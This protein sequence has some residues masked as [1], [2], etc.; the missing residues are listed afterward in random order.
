MKKK[1]F[2]AVCV[3]ALC[4]SLSPAYAEN[5]ETGGNSAPVAENF[6][7]CTYRNVSIGGQLAAVDPDGEPVTF[8]LTTEPVKGTVEI[9]ENGQFVYTPNEGKRGRDYFGYKAVDSSGNESQEATVIISI[10]KQKTDV[11]YSD[12]TG[13]AEE[14]AAV[15]LAEEGLCTGQCIG[16]TYLFDPDGSITRSEF[17]ALCMELTGEPVLEGVMTTGFGDDAE[18]PAWSKSYVSTALMNGCIHGYSDGEAM[19]FDG[20]RGV[21]RAEAA[22]M[23]DTLVQTT[24][25]AT[26]ESDAVPSWACQ[27]VANLSSCDVYPSGSDSAATLTRADAAQM[28]VNAMAVLDRR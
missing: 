4:L 17:L 28:L 25:V 6:E 9:Q 3:L 20:Q 18:I 26:Q 12:M 10:K 24:P 7:L 19:V 23:L 22:V 1:L 15:L 5:A 8:R 13:R 21:T 27:A 16:G 2:T 14:Y 11:M